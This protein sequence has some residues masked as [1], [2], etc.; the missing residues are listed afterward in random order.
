MHRVILSQSLLFTSIIGF[1]I[2]S[3]F[4]YSGRINMSLGFAMCLV[5]VMMFIAS[6]V[7]MTPSG[8]DLESLDKAIREQERF[9]K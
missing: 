9:L 6:V 5:F 2:S 3:I 8:K 7:T 4:T 1:L